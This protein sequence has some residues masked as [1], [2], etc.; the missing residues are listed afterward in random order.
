MVALKSSILTILFLICTT[1]VLKAQAGIENNFNIKIKENHFSAKVKLEK[2]DDHHQLLVTESTNDSGITE[3]R[4]ALLQSSGNSGTLEVESPPTSPISQ[5][6]TPF[7]TLTHRLL[8]E[9]S[10]TTSSTRYDLKGHYFMLP[11]GYIHTGIHN[12]RGLMQH[13]TV[14]RRHENPNFFLIV[15]QLLL[16]DVG[17]NNE[18]E[19]GRS[20]SAEVRIEITPDDSLAQFALRTISPSTRGISIMLSDGADQTLQNEQDPT[21]MPLDDEAC[22]SGDETDSG[23]C[24]CP[25]S[26]HAQAQ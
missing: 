7:Y 6:V 22:S 9:L 8:S 24:N 2:K 20:G 23:E 21:A 19:I 17:I 10:E 18:L 14:T 15:G 5:T 13:I 3:S 12:I 4:H 1:F 25:N 26:A 11:T 16:D